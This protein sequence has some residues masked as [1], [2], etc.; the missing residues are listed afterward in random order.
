[1]A[2]KI[3]DAFIASSKVAVFSKSSCPYCK[4]VKALFGA[5]KQP[6]AALELD[7]PSGWFASS[8][9]LCDQF[10]RNFPRLAVNFAGSEASGADVQSAAAAISGIKSVPQVFIN[11]ARDCAF[12]LKLEL[13]FL[14]NHFDSQASLS[15]DVTRY[16]T[17][18][19]YACDSMLT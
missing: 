2:A 19:H 15:E 7:S 17:M 14:M 3:V 18:V 6:F 10:N 13:I 16:Y 11:G 9:L 1:M 12:L 4:K 5:L 8:R